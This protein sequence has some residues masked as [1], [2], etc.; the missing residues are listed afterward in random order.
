MPNYTA[1]DTSQCSQRES[2]AWT[3]NR[4]NIAARPPDGASVE[5]DQR[6]T[7]VTGRRQ[8]SIFR[9]SARVSTSDANTN[10]RNREKRPLLAG[11]K[12]GTSLRVVEK[13][14]NLNVFF[15][16][17][18][19]ESVESITNYSKDI[20]SDECTVKKLSTKF[21]TYSSF[22]ITCDAK[23]EEKIMRSD[24]W[25]LEML[26][27]QFYGPINPETRQI[28]MN[29]KSHITIIMVEDIDELR[30]NELRCK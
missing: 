30:I 10:H 16:C 15:R 9:R 3:R 17:H 22:V 7:Q 24:E 19:K 20:I 2:N 28:E 4:G 13:I 23:H 5:G 26:I 14:K 25:P 8:E 27:R 6:F 18:P 1:N 21:P 29:A 12:T 11:R